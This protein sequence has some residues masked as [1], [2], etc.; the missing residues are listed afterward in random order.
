MFMYLYIYIYM[1]LLCGSGRTTTDEQLQY[2]EIIKK[3]NNMYV[4]E[5]HYIMGY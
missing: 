4:Y 3:G 1:Y 2:F 5:F